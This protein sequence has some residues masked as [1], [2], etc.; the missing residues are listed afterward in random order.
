MAVRNRG[1]SVKTFT[2]SV[3]GHPAFDESGRARLV[4]EHFG[5]NHFEMPLRPTSFDVLPELV[6][7]YDNPIAD[8]SII[9]TYLLSREIRRHVKVA[10]GGDGGDELT[11]GY[12]HYSTLIRMES[13]GRMTPLP[14]RSSIGHV[15]LNLLPPGFRGRNYLIGFGGRSG[16]IPYINMY[17]DAATRRRLLEPLGELPFAGPAPETSKASIINPGRSAL[18]NATRADFEIT[19]GNVYLPKIDRSSMMASLELRAPLLDRRLI[20]FCFSKLPDSLRATARSRWVLEKR[21]AKRL[22]PEG[23]D[24]AR[25]QGFSIPLHYWFRAGFGSYAKDLL[26]GRKDSFFSRRAI[27]DL[28]GR[29]WV[30]GS[31]PERL[32]ALL[33]IELWR[34]EYRVQGP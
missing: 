14:L 11:G 28:W 25:K 20:E 9:P 6:R 32:F 5:T 12:R 24:L 22:L 10:L 4:A 33:L 17:F 13:L 30:G 15:A 7:E 34:I 21:L 29:Q 2:A 26:L 18:Q 16:V 8:S 1:S 27:S 19:L 31:L 23:F 3:P